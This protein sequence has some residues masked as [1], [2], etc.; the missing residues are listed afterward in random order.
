MPTP[1]PTDL[2][3]AQKAA[4]ILAVHVA[5][6]YRLI[7]SGRLRAWKRIGGRL[8]VSRA[9]AQSLLLPVEVGGANETPRGR[10]HEEEAAAAA[11]ERM[12]ARR[13]QK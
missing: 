7:R 3:T 10:T 11:V 8:R 2:I 5:T 1:P 9:D 13:A 12:K 4:E 6:V